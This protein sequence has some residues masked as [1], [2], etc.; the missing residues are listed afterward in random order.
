MKKSYIYGLTLFLSLSGLALAGPIELVTLNTSS[1]SGT[2]GSIDFEFDPA[3]PASPSATATITNFTGA[4]F[5][6]GSNINDDGSSGGPIPMPITINNTLS[7]PNDNFEAVIF[8]NSLSFDVA[9]NGTAI[10]NPGGQPNQQNLFTFSVF[11]DEGG[12]VPAT[13]LT[14]DPNGI[15]A[16]IMITDEGGLVSDAISPEAS[17]TAAPATVTPEPGAFGLM[18]C[19]LIALGALKR[20]LS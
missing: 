12:T 8:G 20:R 19:G 18:G 3:S 10:T 13:S 14:T 5:V 2:T 9:F 15:V 16:N 11:T 6:A 1:L 7:I 17:I 4:T